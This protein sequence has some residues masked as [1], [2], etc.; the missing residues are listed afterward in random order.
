MDMSVH[1]SIWKVYAPFIVFA[2][3]RKVSIFTRFDPPNFQ[4]VQSANVMDIADRLTP[5]QEL[6]EYVWFRL[7]VLRRPNSN[8]NIEDGE[9]PL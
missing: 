1:S 9:V 5:P 6:T 4:L 8:A 3:H 7:N 2:C